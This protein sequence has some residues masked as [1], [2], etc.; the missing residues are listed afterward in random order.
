MDN[1]VPIPQED[2]DRIN[3]MV[4]QY[5]HQITNLYKMAWLQ[6]GIKAQMEARDALRAAR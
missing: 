3:A 5:R 1:D 6:G 2:Q 4:E